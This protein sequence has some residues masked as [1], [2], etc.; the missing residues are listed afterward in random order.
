MLFASVR[1]RWICRPYNSP[2]LINARGFPRVLFGMPEMGFKLK[3]PPDPPS[4]GGEGVGPEY[5]LSTNT[6]RIFL[7]CQTKTGMRK[8][9]DTTEP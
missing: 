7:P 8:R 5:C 9:L 2:L 4:K 1:Y 6:G 3:V